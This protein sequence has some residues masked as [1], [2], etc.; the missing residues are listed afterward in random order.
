MTGQA[1]RV[2]GALVAAGLVEPAARERAES[3]VTRAL[4]P[5]QE[6][7]QKPA[8]EPGGRGGLVEIVGYAGGALVV[9][10]LLLF[11]GQEW[12]D[13]AEAAQVASLAGVAVLLGVAGFVVGRVA[14]GYAELQ[15][16][17]DDARRRLTSALWTAGALA[18]SFAAGLQISLLVSWEYDGAAPLGGA[19]TLLGCSAVAYRFAPSALGLAAMAACGLVAITS[20]LSLL[21]SES[22]STL[23]PGLLILGWGLA[24]LAAAERGWFHATTVARAL[25]VPI[26]LLGAQMPRFDGHHNGISYVLLVLVAVACF[27]AYLRTPAWPYL[28]G[29]VAAITL[30]VPEAVIDWTEGSLGVAGGILVA[31]LTLLGA[32]LAGLRVRRK[33]RT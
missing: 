11:L 23:W 8:Q 20:G 29:G 31:G 9:A 18:A 24:W 7:A 5:A 6:P 4:E 26:V 13:L 25:G 17:G 1:S 32:S 10:A 2:V 16:G 15:P 27:A 14:G 3:V 33:A 21:P 22:D 19:L 30:V 28:V 12:P